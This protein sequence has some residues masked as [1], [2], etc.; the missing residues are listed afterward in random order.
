MKRV[1]LSV[2]IKAWA[3]LF[4]FIAEIT[5]PGMISTAKANGNPSYDSFMQADNSQWVD[6]FTGDFSYNIPLMSVPGSKGGFP[7]NLHYRAGVGMDQEASWVGLGWHLNPGAITRQLNGIPDDFSGDEIITQT[8]YTKPEKSISLQFDAVG[9]VLKESQAWTEAMFEEMEYAW[10]PESYEGVIGEDSPTFDISSN[11]QVFLNLNNYYGMDLNVTRNRNQLVADKEMC[12]SQELS[13]LSVGSNGVLRRNG[14]MLRGKLSDFKGDFSRWLVKPI[15]SEGKTSLHQLTKWIPGA[16]S[17]LRYPSSTPQVNL[18]FVSHTYGFELTNWKENLPTNWITSNSGGGVVNVKVLTEENQTMNFPA[19]GSIYPNR[20]QNLEVLEDCNL[21]SHTTPTIRTP[22]LSAP[23]KQN[24]FWMVSGPAVQ[25]SF[26]SF[27]NEFGVYS[28]PPRIS[29]VNGGDGGLEFGTEENG[30]SKFGLDASYYDGKT[31]SGPWSSDMGGIENNLDHNSAYSQGEEPF[32]FQ[33]MDEVVSHVSNP[34]NQLGGDEPHAFKLVWGDTD[35]GSGGWLPSKK[36]KALTISSLQHRLS[37]AFKNRTTRRTL[38]EYTTFKH[39]SIDPEAGDY[40][41]TLDLVYGGSTNPHVSGF[42]N[43]I[44]EYSLV[45]SQGFKQVYGIPVYNLERTDVSWRTDELWST[46]SHPVQPYS[47]TVDKHMK[48]GFDH[49][50]SR[51]DIPEYSEA[52]LLTEL[53]SNNYID[54]KGDGPTADDAGFWVKLDYQ[55]GSNF[56]YRSP[57]LDA[58]ADPGDYSNPGDDMFSYSYGV[59]EQIYVKR[60]ETDTHYAE[61][62]I[63][64]REDNRPVKTEDNSSLA[65]NLSWGTDECSYKLDQIKLFKKDEGGQDDLL[66]TVHFLYDYLLCEGTPS[67]AAT[68]AAK[69][70]LTSVYTTYQDSP[71]EENVHVFNYDESDGYRNPDYSFVNSDRWGSYT[72]VY[73]GN[74]ENR[75]TNQYEDAQ[76]QDDHASAWSL[77]SILLP[78]GSEMKIEYEADRYCKVQDKGA[79]SMYKIAF[80]GKENVLLENQFN[81]SYGT[82]TKQYNRIYFELPDNSNSS[83]TA[84]QS[85]VGDKVFIKLYTRLKGLIDNPGTTATD[86]VESW[87]DVKASG[88]DIYQGNYYGYV[89]LELADLTSVGIGSVNPLRLAAWE[90]IRTHRI[91][92]TT[93]I[94]DDDF[95]LEDISGWLV[96]AINSWVSNIQQITSFYPSAHILGWANRADL[97]ATNAPSFI[98]M[99]SR[100]FKVGGGHR[101]KEI[102]VID[103]WSEIND[104]NG[105]QENIAYNVKY[106]YEDSNGLCTGVASNE[107]INANEEN[108]LITARAFNESNYPVSLRAGTSFSE[109]PVGMAYY[110]T[111]TVGYHLVRMEVGGSN[112]LLLD[113]QAMT[114]GVVQSEFYTAA[115][116]PTINRVTNL[117][118]GNGTLLKRALP[119]AIPVPYTGWQVFVNQGFSQG[120]S[121]ENNDMHGKL[122]TRKTFSAKGYQD[123]TPT[124]TTSYVYHTESDGSLQSEIDVLSELGYVDKRLTGVTYDFVIFANENNHWNVDAGILGGT[125]LESG[126]PLPHVQPDAEYFHSNSRLIS[127]TKVINRKGLLKEVITETDGSSVKSANLVYCSQGTGPLLTQVQN[128][129]RDNTYSYSQPAY[130]FYPN[131]KSSFTH[132]NESILISTDPLGH[133]TTG[134]IENFETI[135]GDGDELV[136]LINDQWVHAWV[137]YDNDWELVDEQGAALADLSAVTASVYRPHRR[138]LQSTRVGSVVSMNNPLDYLYVDDFLSQWNAMMDQ[139]GSALDPALSDPQADMRFDHECLDESNLLGFSTDWKEVVYNDSDFG[140]LTISPEDNGVSGECGNLALQFELPEEVDESDGGFTLRVEADQFELFNSQGL[141]VATTPVLDAHVDWF[142]CVGQRCIKVLHADAINLKDDWDETYLSERAL[143]TTDEAGY[144][145]AVSQNEQRYGKKGI[146]RPEY[147]F[148]YLTDREQSD[149]PTTKIDRDGQYP[150]FKWFDWRSDNPI[151]DN[152]DWMWKSKVDRYTIDGIAVQSSNDLPVSSASLVSIDGSQVIAESM[153]AE[154]SEVL[155]ESFEIGAGVYD[156]A[157]RGNG[158]LFL[159]L[160]TEI[161]ST[162]NHTGDYS[163]KVPSGSSIPIN[164][165]PGE[166]SFDRYHPTFINGESSAHISVWAYTGGGAVPQIAMTS[167]GGQSP[168]TLVADVTEAIDDWVKLEIDYTFTSD[169]VTYD[170]YLSSSNAADT[171][172]DDLRICPMDASMVTYVYSSDNRRL[173]ATLDDNNYA[174]VY[175]YDRRGQLVQTKIETIN[176]IQ[177]ISTGRTLL[178]NPQLPQ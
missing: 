84:F 74:P 50:F 54:F 101:V 118:E 58:Y 135:I 34:M 116:F 25:G 167:S 11:F 88:V 112:Q 15:G 147:S 24:D 105:N 90:D 47:S 2:R 93:E 121:I 134:L 19:Y 161:V 49:F 107:P 103:T 159:P 129:W 123:N 109:L 111:P 21:E 144:V 10:S 171:Y 57:Y 80:T 102:K 62:L 31:Y 81:P 98:R 100:N 53:Y 63:S 178:R 8:R 51:D 92:L 76:V 138:N 110:P 158:N 113:Q 39:K 79:M 139:S 22:N 120:V 42:E 33:M 176:G 157:V 130:A 72:N 7:L 46:T 59:K 141:M 99:P 30:D 89:D 17:L 173:L 149:D 16:S 96:S 32:Y 106:F 168:V 3:F 52:H 1:S 142:R 37:D 132:H 128:E 150:S 127:T 165:D 162:H 20:S 18:Q 12:Y 164:I 40:Q 75:Y 148:L 115:D 136:C 70:T 97:T 154:V 64:P 6:P 35:F 133:I 122:K 172:F 151:V 163:L 140:E 174:T 14:S 68:N 66:Q 61:F 65:A 71:R 69:L 126:Y 87:V 56:K 29:K 44:A 124:A 67:S 13:G 152:P 73:D 146:E 104:Y 95:Q 48:Q 160:S 175:I 125:Q 38:I 143:L 77:R 153:N 43:Q 108:G 170:L 26:R 169:Q 155:S 114:S 28:N 83:S 82:I 85:V 5:V 41:R 23:V 137:N 9:E 86:Y 36:A 131:T 166:N 55:K 94:V 45:N 177:T 4:L 117:S 119:V 156:E 60:I 91:D 78:G 145:L 27:S